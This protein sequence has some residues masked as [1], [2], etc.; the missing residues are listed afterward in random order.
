MDTK[1]DIDFVY[2]NIG[3]IRYER[4]ENVADVKTLMFNGG[5]NWK[6]K[7]LSLYLT[8]SAYN[9]EYRKHEEKSNN[10][11]Y[12]I[13]FVP[14]LRLKG[15]NFNMQAIY[16]GAHHY[17]YYRTT[18]SFRVSLGASKTIKKLTFTLRALNVFRK[19]LRTYS[20]SE[21]FTNEKFYDNND[22]AIFQAGILYKFGKEQ[23]RRVRTY[24]NTN[25][26]QLNR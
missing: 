23:K 18:E 15:Y 6:Y 2:Y 17:A 11:N 19:I 16:Y 26:I 20:W 10:W 25:P 12:D 4:Y 9:T 3:D 7:A 21:T 22:T 5:I 24:L 13:R 1:D 8:G 14:Q